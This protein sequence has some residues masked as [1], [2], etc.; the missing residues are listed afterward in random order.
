MSRSVRYLACC[1]ALF[2][3]ASVGLAADLSRI[4]VLGDSIS[5]GYQSDGLV[6]AFQEQSYAAFVARQ[7]GVELPLPLIGFPGIP[8]VL[9]LEDIGPPP[10]LSRTPGTSVGRVDPM[11]QSR[12]LAVPGHDVLDALDARPDLPIDSAIDLVLGVPGL[13]GGV[14]LSQIEWAEQLAPTTV[15]VW[16]GSNDVLQ[17]ATQADPSKMT[18]PEVFER[19]FA[20]LTDRLEALDASVVL[21]NIPDVTVIPY[22]T[23]RREVAFVYGVPDDLLGLAL[24]LGP[25]DFV[26]LPGLAFVEPILRGEIPGPLPPEVVLTAEE[27]AE[28]AERVALFN[29]IIADSADRLGGRVVDVNG[30][31]NAADADGREVCDRVLSTGFGGGL[32]SLDGIHPSS[33]A[34]AVVANAVIEAL[35]DLGAQLG[36]VDECRVVATDPYVPSG[37]SFT[38]PPRVPGGLLRLP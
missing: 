14:S 16:L 9:Q 37:A 1:I 30:I 23:P 31:L 20:E 36:S 22:L 27:A 2:V 13:F 4:V 8:A 38:R 5:A 15:L 35:R 18:E 33:T 29:G 21:L 24:G 32:F 25:G 6:D 26:T 12:N 3:A 10:V 19:G 28:I 11:V 7:A 17:G 34:H